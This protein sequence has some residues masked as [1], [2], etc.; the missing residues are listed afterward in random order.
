M[1][2]LAALFLVASAFPARFILEVYLT[3]YLASKNVLFILFSTEVLYMVIKGIYV[4]VYKARKQQNLYFLQLVVIIVVGI[5]FNAAGYF[6]FKSNEAIAGAT[7]L[8][9]IC[10]YGICSFSVK[11]LIPTW[12]E[13]LILV[14]ALPT[15]IICGVFLPAVEGCIIYLAVICVL[16]FALMREETTFMIGYLKG[17]LKGKVKKRR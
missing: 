14:I 13:L 5:I 2:L 9:V 3:K 17:M 16:A 6:L 8:S 10:W 12:K 4:N 15:Y 11:E 1:C 7:L